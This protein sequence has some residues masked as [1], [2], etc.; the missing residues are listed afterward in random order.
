[1]SAARGSPSR[2]ARSAAPA[3]CLSRSEWMSRWQ[4]GQ[5]SRS[6]ASWIAQPGQ[7]MLSGMGRGLQGRRTPGIDPE[8]AV[9]RKL[10]LPI[11]LPS[12][13]QSEEDDQQ[14]DEVLG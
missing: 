13:Q 5:L 6:G 8:G 9:D 12:L 10:D 1:M 14:A 2:S 4:L 7:R 11:Q 3:S